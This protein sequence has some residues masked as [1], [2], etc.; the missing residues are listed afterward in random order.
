MKKNLIAA[1]LLVPLF[2]EAQ[3]E[4]RADLSPAE[5][6]Q[7]IKTSSSAVTAQFALEKLKSWDEK[8]TSLKANFEQEVVFKNADIKRKISGTVTY[9]KPNLL[10]I[11][12][13]SP[14]KQLIITDRKKIFIY[15]PQEKE[16]Y[17]ADWEAWKKNL[18]NSLG[19]LLDFGNYSS[20]SEKNSAE[21]YEEKDAWR[22]EL[23]GK[24]DPSAY[25]LKL[26]LSRDDFFPLG[27]SLEVGDSMIKT[28]LVSVEKNAEIKDSE[29]E[30]PKKVKAE[31]I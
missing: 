16:A 2:C 29:F 13:F 15:K 12:H 10:K 3:Q 11:E 23:R 26:F 9:K 21:L 22:L 24:K 30:R 4:K 1:M 6:K 5:Q 20:L 8:L 19:A 7:D 27:A 17:E 28:R 31:K 14:K 25:V 18:D